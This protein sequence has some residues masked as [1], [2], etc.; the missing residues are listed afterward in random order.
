MLGL[1]I[2]CVLMQGEQVIAYASRQ[3][4]EH[5]KNY[6]THDLELAAVI[7]AIKTW[8]HYLYGE[9]F[10]IKS[11]HKSLTYPFTQKDLNMRQRRWL[12]LLKDYDCDIQY[13][14]G[15]ANVVAD[16]LSRKWAS[17]PE[18]GPST[19]AALC[20]AASSS[21]EI[22]EEHIIETAEDP[23]EQGL[24]HK[25]TMMFVALKISPSLIDEVKVAILQDPYLKTVQEDLEKGTCNPYFTLESDK[26]LKYRG[27]LC[28]PESEDRDIGGRVMDRSSLHSIFGT[29]RKY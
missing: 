1:G 7:Y 21:M 3:L 23:V 13:H 20:V 8:R 16:A 18:A 4:K 11:D 6:P 28:I 12:E 24:I 27:R 9:K 25:F 19:N 17:K 14:P 10:Q 22:D 15:K 29:S 5:E 26:V 2:G